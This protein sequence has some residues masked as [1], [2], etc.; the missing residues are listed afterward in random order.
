MADY[1]RLGRTIFGPPRMD[2]LFERHQGIA[3]RAH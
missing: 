1:T 2:D 3:S